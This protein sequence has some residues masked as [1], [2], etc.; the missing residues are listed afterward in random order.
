M[1]VPYLYPIL[2]FLV[3]SINAQQHYPAPKDSESLLFYIQHS[4]NQNTYVYNAPIENGRFRDRDPIEVHR[5]L[6]EKDGQR[7]PITAIQ[8]GMAYGVE[9]EK[10]N[11][12]LYRFY[13]VSF[14]KIPLYL[15][16]E[17]GAPK[18]YVTVNGN[19]M[20]LERIFLHL[21]D[22]FIPHI[23]PE[24]A[25]LSGVGYDSNEP[26]SEKYTF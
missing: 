7:L 5:I 3:H 21:K 16:L 4:H 15:T 10:I 25:T 8:R 6:Y 12:S 18:V 26:V 13:L 9:S 24:Y 17:T 1:K 11:D 22:S 23:K 14:K 2:L 19:K 20:Y